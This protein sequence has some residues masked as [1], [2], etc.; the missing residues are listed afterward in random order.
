MLVF[1]IFCGTMMFMMM[2]GRMGGPPARFTDE[3]HA[4]EILKE[5]YARGE[6]SLTEYEERRRVLE[7]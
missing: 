4:L 2:R 3:S 7:V 5:R 6:I 1:I